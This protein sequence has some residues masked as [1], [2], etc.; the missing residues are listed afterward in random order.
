MLGLRCHF[1]CDVFTLNANKVFF[2]SWFNVDP[3]LGKVEM[4]R[5]AWLICVYLLRILPWM[6]MANNT[7]AVLFHLGCQYL[8]EVCIDQGR[9]IWNGV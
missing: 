2:A 9:Q 7:L 5:R 3:G 4:R 1:V 8:V 6:C